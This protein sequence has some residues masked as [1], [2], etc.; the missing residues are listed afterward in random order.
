[1]PAAWGIIIITIPLCGSPLLRSKDNCPEQGKEA[2]QALDL[3]FIIL[4]SKI[5]PR[6]MMLHSGL[7]APKVIC[8][9]ACPHLKQTGLVS[10]WYKPRHVFMKEVLLWPIYVSAAVNGTTP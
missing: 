7:P 2:G 10:S 3:L 1:M 4:T 9:A 8:T 6:T 5:K